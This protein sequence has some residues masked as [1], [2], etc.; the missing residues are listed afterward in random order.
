MNQSQGL[1]PVW[2]VAEAGAAEATLEALGEAVELAR[3]DAPGVVAVGPAETRDALAPWPGTGP[4]G[5]CCSGRRARSPLP[6]PGAP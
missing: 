3:P 1:T 6:R 2:V 5:W 4:A